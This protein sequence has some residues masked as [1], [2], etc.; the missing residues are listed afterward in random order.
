MLPPLAWFGGS[1]ARVNLGNLA[2]SSA[3]ALGRRPKPG[4]VGVAHD[5][6]AKA[7]TALILGS[8]QLNT[9]ATWASPALH[10]PSQAQ[11]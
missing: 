5:P 1:V 4:A 11:V 2:L 8:H 7:E 9:C 6:E 3:L 10:L